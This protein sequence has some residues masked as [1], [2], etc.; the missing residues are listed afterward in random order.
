MQNNEAVD[1][2]YNTHRDNL[3]NMSNTIIEELDEQFEFNPS[4]D[5]E[6]IVQELYVD[7]LE[8]SDFIEKAFVDD[9]NLDL[10]YFFIVLKSKLNTIIIN[11]CS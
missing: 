9:D 11:N 2:L 8:Q 3:V 6:D 10:G 5:A 1:K 7:L 4:L